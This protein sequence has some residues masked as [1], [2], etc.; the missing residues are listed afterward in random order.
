[1][2]FYFSIVEYGRLTS[3]GGDCVLCALISSCICFLSNLRLSHEKVKACQRILIFK[4]TK[5][6]I[7]FF[8]FR[9]MQLIDL[10]TNVLQKSID[11]SM[12]FF[13]FCTLY[14]KLNW[15]F[16]EDLVGSE[17]SRWVWNFFFPGRNFLLLG[18]L[19][20][21]F[22]CCRLLC[23]GFLSCRLLGFLCC[24]FLGLG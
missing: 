20:S 5:M 23:C 1:M 24:R 18:R 7:F 3:Y 8:V 19:L 17:K 16:W 12:F 6:H 15:L 22:L 13:M 9:R 11:I 14:H 4:H 21:G 2:T 10:S